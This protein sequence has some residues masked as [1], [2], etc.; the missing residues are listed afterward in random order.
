MMDLFT[1][2]LERKE[3][4]FDGIDEIQLILLDAN[5]KEQLDQADVRQNKARDLDGL[6]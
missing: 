6:L 4:D 5:T 3:F 2:I 1:D